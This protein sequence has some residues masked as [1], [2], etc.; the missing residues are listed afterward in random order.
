MSEGNQDIKYNVQI[1]QAQVVIIGANAAY[2]GGRETV[3]PLTTAS[4]SESVITI[5]GQNNV[6]KGYRISGR[7]LTHISTEGCR[8]RL[9]MRRIKGI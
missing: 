1:G 5:L 3:S 6:A 7:Y 9:V 8:R 2:L 4:S